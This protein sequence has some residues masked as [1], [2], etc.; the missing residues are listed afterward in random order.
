MQMELFGHHGKVK[1]LFSKGLSLYKSGNYR[2]AI[3]YY[4]EALLI[5]SKFADGWYNKGLV[6]FKLNNYQ[7][8]I[9]CYD[10]VL[11]IDPEFADGWYSKGLV[12]YELKSYQD[13]INC[14]DKV[15]E[16]DPEFAEAWYSKG[17]VFY[18]LNSYQDAINCYD[19]ALEIDPEFADVW[20]GKAFIFEETKQ[21]LLVYFYYGKALEIEPDSAEMWYHRGL[22]AAASRWDKTSYRNKLEEALQDPLFKHLWI[23]ARH[24]DLILNISEADSKAVECYDKALEINPDNPEFVDAW[25]NKGLALYKSW[26]NQDAINCYDKVLELNPEFADAWYNK[27]LAL[28][29]LSKYMGA[30]EC[31]NKALSIEWN[32]LYVESKL[33]AVESLEW[34]I[35]EKLL[36]VSASGRIPIRT[37]LKLQ[38]PIGKYNDR[39]SSVIIEFCKKYLSTADMD[40][41]TAILWLHQCDYSYSLSEADNTDLLQKL[42]IRLY[43]RTQKHT[44]YES[45][46]YERILG[47][48]KTYNNA[49][50]FIQ[51]LEK[52]RKILLKRHIDVSYTHI[53]KI[54]A[55]LSKESLDKEQEARLERRVLSICKR[56]SRVPR[57]KK[58]IVKEYL[59]LFPRSD[60]EIM[61]IERIFDKFGLSYTEMEVSNLLKQSVEEIELE[62]FESN[63]GKKVETQRIGDFEDLNGYQFEDYLRE[64]FSLLGYEAIVTKRSS[65]QGADL[66]I[67]KNGVTTAVQAKKYAGSVSNK[68]VQEIVAAKNYYKAGKTMVVTTGTFTKSAY[69]LAKSNDVILWDGARLKKIVEHINSK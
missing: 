19:K 62:E 69:E 61:I 34:Q 22:M 4:D 57:N 60:D 52:I 39:N 5:D 18:E 26:K 46:E 9:K 25:Y 68:A 50:Q 2:G 7:G 49:Y 6:L 35:R 48:A 11:E 21:F 16:I 12:F 15:L 8:A 3:K 58:Q 31:Y 51:D 63:L 29:R 45:V 32:D 17:L 47:W 59:R 37:A 1:K 56:I 28:Y 53:I 10:K 66:I 64:L 40:F 27:G 38:I 43:Q 54:M 14:Y 24:S 13:A 33:D 23:I 20:R 36:R 65:D 55:R 67:K 44:S 41:K 42:C 30:I